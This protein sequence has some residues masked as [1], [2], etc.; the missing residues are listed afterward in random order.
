MSLIQA[1]ALS[2]VRSLSLFGVFALALAPALALPL[3]V[4]RAHAAP[5][6]DAGINADPAAQK[7]GDDKTRTSFPELARRFRNHCVQVY[8]H[9][10]SDQGVSPP[11]GV[12]A[13][14]IK[15]ERPTPIGGYWWDDNHVVI[16]DQVLQD[17]YIRA[18]ELSLPDSGT[19]YPA[20]VAGRFQ[21]LQAVLLEVLPNEDGR[22]P[23]STPLSF[24]DGDLEDSYV[25]SYEWLDGEWRIKAKSG[26]SGSTLSDADTQIVSFASSGV[27]LDEDG[28]A[29]GLAFGKEA[30]LNPDPDAQNYWLGD[31]LKTTPLVT[32]AQTAEAT[33]ALRNRL[34]HAV[35]EARFR[36]RL[37]IDEEDEDEALQ[38]AEEMDDNQLRG[39][40]A[41]IR[42]AAFVV[43]KRHLLVP[44]PLPPEGIAR[45]ES[46]A[47]VLPD[48]YS[49][50]GHFAGAL[51]EY[52]AVL[53][54][55]DETLPLH[56]LPAGFGRLNP[57]MNEA[58]GD[59]ESN[60]DGPKQNPDRHG[61]I[62]RWQIDY[63]LGRRREQTDH[64]RWLGTFRG[65]RSDI[66]VST[67]TN[68]DNGTLAFDQNGSLVA[69]SLTPRLIRSRER[70]SRTIL[71]ASPGF[72]PLDFLA[73]RFR[74]GDVF[75]P[76]LM[77]VDEED[78]QRL[79]D[80]GVEFQS[81]DANTAKLFNASHATRG[82]KI[83]VLVTHVYPGST[84]EK[85]GIQEKD[86]LLRLYVEGR[87]EPMEL[88]ST[89]I[90]LGL[91]KY[92]MDMTSDT[93]RNMIRF[94]P[95][96]WPS[97]ENVISL[98]LTAAGPGREAVIEY[99]RN[100]EAKRAKFTTSYFKPDYRSA[101]KN[102]FPALGLTVKPITFEVARYFSR[103]D[104][105]GVI[106][107]R[108][109]V[110][111]KSS[112]SG[113]HH[114]LLVTHVDGERVEGVDDFRAKVEAFEDG[115]AQSVELTVE[116]FGKT[117]LVKIE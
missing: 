64:D 67:L 31:G 27:L 88:R 16:P 23:R 4:S 112:V 43:G 80:S 37:N 20:R 86:I 19:L 79:V 22:R 39:G 110:G 104:K 1:F 13:E 54:E 68:E 100:G 42:S 29:I 99:L 48:G 17:R 10:K 53:V 87:R 14:D 78:G 81:L 3:A 36:I 46:I 91:N 101:R 35:L 107:S 96:P 94:M 40:A 89:A 84:A 97:R 51:R 98:L 106:I 11:V 34:K 113:L 82:G 25:F 45:I 105:S 93:F 56:D 103:P 69:V 102:K 71:K 33:E 5:P 62:Q 115:L 59:T 44:V 52:M 73:L 74:A 108:V 38:W 117:R 26:I 75:D 6:A 111:G 95:P 116:G 58:N 85:I 49:T 92:D 72:R 8:V 114:Y 32:A 57:L 12:F 60:D 30:V 41:E 50:T 90:T 70:T 76:A 18:I 7:D 109:E 9:A 21:T 63:S 66:V 2:Y 65:Y 15:H 47:V 61:L 28:H 83:G 77:P 24:T 55:I